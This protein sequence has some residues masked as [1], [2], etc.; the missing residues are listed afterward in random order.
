MAQG[1]YYCVHL[2]HKETHGNLE[3][4]GTSPKRGEWWGE[5]AASGETQRRRGGSLQAEQQPQR[6]VW[7]SLTEGKPQTPLRSVEYLSGT[8]KKMLSFHFCGSLVT[9]E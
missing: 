8:L 3:W 2:T 9:S 6:R 5:D 7:R 1:E 4:L